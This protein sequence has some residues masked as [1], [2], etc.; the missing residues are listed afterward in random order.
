VAHAPVAPLASIA[1]VY[2]DAIVD[3]DEV[4]DIANID[5]VADIV[6]DEEAILEKNTSIADDNHNANFE[7]E[8]GDDENIY[9]HN[10][11]HDFEHD[12]LADND[13]PHL[14]T[15]DQVMD[16]KYGKRSGRYNLRDRKEANY[17]HLFT[18]CSMFDTI[19]TQ[20]SMKKGLDKF[21]DKGAEAVLKE[22]RQ[23]DI[24]EVLEPV[25]AASLSK[26]QRMTALVYFMFLKEKRDGD[27]KAR[28][29]SDGRKQR[30]YTSKD[31]ASSPTVAKESVF[32]SCTID[33]NEHRDVATVDIPGAFLHAIMKEIVH[34]QLE[35]MMDELLIKSNPDKYASFAVIEKGKAVLY[36][37]AKKALYGTL[38]APLLLWEKLT[39]TLNSWG[40]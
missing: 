4:A 34:I 40:F 12:M 24:R 16:Q 9:G 17:S 29:C 28:E 23:L 22:L 2:D 14:P 18:V 25:N 19:F 15:I 13:M 30:I 36:L 7:S 33:A 3:I 38:K 11:D 32:M 20:Y 31:E 37:L 8:N 10:E 27:I 39:A 21:G 1:G 26:A 35:G 5:E 6:N